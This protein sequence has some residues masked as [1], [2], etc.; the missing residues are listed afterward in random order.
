M[1]IPLA[2]IT[3]DP[4]G[5]TLKRI[6]RR[7]DPPADAQNS[8][9]VVPLPAEPVAIGEDWNLPQDV[10]VTLGGGQVKSIKLRQHYTLDKVA[11]GV[12]TIAVTT[13]VLTPVNNP[14]IQVQII[15]R[16]TQG[17]VRFDIDAGRVISQQL[18]LDERVLGFHGPDS[19]MHLYGRFTEEYLPP[20]EKTAA[21]AKAAK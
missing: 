15:Q 11:S 1:G 18:D 3:I 4:S 9:M 2:T 17:S 13:Q 12:A 14:E 8:L 6:D 5:K 16:M 20:A 10:T 21:K 7:P 19:N